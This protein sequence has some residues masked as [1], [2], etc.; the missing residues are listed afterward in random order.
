MLIDSHNHLYLP[1]F[2]EDRSACIARAVEA[3]VGL[4]LLPNVDVATIAQMHSVCDAWPDRCLPMMGL[5]PC[6]VDD[7][8]E[9][10]LDVIERHL[11][12]PIRK[13]WAVGEIGLDLYWDKTTLSRQV[14]AFERQI[15]WAKAL[16][17][18]I[19]IHVRDAFDE[20]FEVIDSMN[21]GRLRGVFHCFTGTEAQ[22]R[23]IIDYGGFKLGIGGVITFKN[24]G[25]NQ[26][27]HNIALEHI[28][29]ETDSPYLA[30]VPHRGKR[31]EPA[32]LKI[33][34]QTLANCYKTDVKIIEQVTSQNCIDL[35]RLNHLTI[36]ATDIDSP[37]AGMV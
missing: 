15:Q 31:N 26:F 24:G 37:P 33:I 34:A 16:D 32:Y 19:V 14:E 30:P 29:L 21:D 17:L 8:H 11:F 10:Q 4:L 36:D 23:K 12:M 9:E 13:Y 5:H 2:D 22:A 27:I 20:T 18:P 25:L 28:V 7:N 35:F 6:S 1:Q 3:N